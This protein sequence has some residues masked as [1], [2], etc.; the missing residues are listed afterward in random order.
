MAIEILDP[1]DEGVRVF[2]SIRHVLEHDKIVSCAQLFIRYFEVAPKLLV[3]Q[4]D[5]IGLVDG[6][7]A[8]NCR[9]SLRLQQRSFE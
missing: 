3:C 2:D 7:D 4:N 1:L 8:I 5:V 9:F 6:E